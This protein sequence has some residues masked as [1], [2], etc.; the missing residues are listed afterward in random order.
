MKRKKKKK[1]FQIMGL[2]D[3]ASASRR[4]AI[5]LVIS[6]ISCAI[7]PQDSVFFFY[8][9]APLQGPF[10]KVDG[11]RVPF[12]FGRPARSSTDSSKISQGGYQAREPLMGPPGWAHGLG[13]RQLRDGVFDAEASS[14]CGL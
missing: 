10:S 12:F 9:R 11:R 14:S 5:Q 2:L 3:V 1:T 4:W 7:M 8:S 6:L 13:I